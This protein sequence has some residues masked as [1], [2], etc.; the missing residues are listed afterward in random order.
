[1]SKLKWEECAGFT[2]LTCGRLTVVQ[3]RWQRS[4]RGWHVYT[5]HWFASIDGVC[6]IFADLPLYDDASRQLAKQRALVLWRKKYRRLIP[7][8]VAAQKELRGVRVR[9]SRGSKL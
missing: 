1:M 8:L 2:R 6:E 7:M 9:S 4:A 3:V 5:P